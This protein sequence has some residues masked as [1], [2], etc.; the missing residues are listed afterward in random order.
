MLANVP[1]VTRACYDNLDTVAVT[2]EVQ[3]Q[4]SVYL[5]DGYATAGNP[6]TWEFALYDDVCS[7]L[8]SAPT[9]CGINTI[10]LIAVPEEE[11]VF[12]R[13]IGPFGEIMSSELTL[14]DAMSG[15][16]QETVAKA[17][18]LYRPGI[19]DLDFIANLDTFLL[20][21]GYITQSMAPELFEYDTGETEWAPD[22]QGGST[23]ELRP[24]GIPDA[25]EL[26]LLQYVLQHPQFDMISVGGAS[27]VH[28]WRSWETNL[29]LAQTQINNPQLD[30]LA[31]LVA[32]YMTIGTPGHRAAMEKLLDDYYAIALD[33]SAYDTS[34]TSWF[35]PEG[36]LDNDGVWNIEEWENVEEALTGTV[37]P[38][39]MVEETA[40]S[41]TDANDIYT[42]PPPADGTFVYDGDVIQEGSAEHQALI[43]DATGENG[44]LQKGT[45]TFSNNGELSVEAVI[46]DPSGFDSVPMPTGSATTCALGRKFRVTVKGDTRWF[47]MWSAA[48]NL[49]DGSPATSETFILGNSSQQVGP[50]K[51]PEGAITLTGSYLEWSGVGPLA[52][53][54][55][56][57]P[58]GGNTVLYVA[59]DTYVK[60]EITDS[61][62]PLADCQPS[63]LPSAWRL[64]VDGEWSYKTSLTLRGG[65]YTVQASEFWCCADVPTW[66][67]T[68]SGDGGVE[69]FGLQGDPSNIRGYI[70]GAVTDEGPSPSC[71]GYD[72]DFVSQF[73]VLPGFQLET[74]SLPGEGTQ[75]EGDVLPLISF[76]GGATANATLATGAGGTTASTEKKST[77]TVLCET[78]PGIEPGGSF[79][80]YKGSG[81]IAVGKFVMRVTQC[82]P[83][84]EPIRLTANP[85]VGFRFVRWKGDGDWMDAGGSLNPYGKMLNAADD[86]YEHWVTYSTIHVKCRKDRTLTALFLKQAVVYERDTGLGDTDTNAPGTLSAI[87]YQVYNAVDETPT[88]DIIEQM[89]YSS[90]YVYSGHEVDNL[91]P[92]TLEI[93]G[94]DYRLV[95]CNSCES[96]AGMLGDIWMSTLSS[97]SFVG[98]IG[99]VSEFYANWFDSIF[100]SQIEAGDSVAE[101]AQYARDKLG[102]APTDPTH[103]IWKGDATL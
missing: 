97:D 67:H 35:G 30:Y 78:K 95:L 9:E 90:V 54:I 6:K 33:A 27:H 79:N 13:W 63:G 1:G 38:E 20:A 74:V 60:V 80:A 49:I 87:G 94:A 47:K 86:D 100:W 32:A 24:N 39:E 28:A 71:Q 19:A 89:K 65:G 73:Q 23:L 3:G 44:P 93:P 46:I 8:C 43:E 50:G 52:D 92:D 31:R 7:T 76:A 83:D 25:V 4:G 26:Y 36:D 58:S 48:N 45:V 70:Y 5:G 59:E 15:S 91:N 16:W 64:K 75:C 40:S 66:T 84:T 41:A 102:Y 98:W 56:A 2:V 34:V 14:E 77:L 101:A 42:P 53:E 22:G 103:P 96:G 72:E 17:E 85:Q 29:A 69:V 57:V 51:K 88:S 55:R 62:P 21:I 11:W 68:L 18:F 81:S 99:L 82:S 37:T 12:H 61:A 10:D